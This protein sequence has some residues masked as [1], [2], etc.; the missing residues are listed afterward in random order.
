MGY[1]AVGAGHPPFAV[2]SRCRR[3]LSPHPSL[4]AR[5][6]GNYS[7]ATAAI[8]RF[9]ARAGQTAGCSKLVAMALQ[10]SR[11]RRWFAIGG[12]AVT[13]LV[14]GAYFYARHR[15]QNALKEVPG[16]MGINIQQSADGFTVSKS[17]A[18]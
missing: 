5:T 8:R 4:P 9:P 11:L 1:G 10:I 12:I 7:S 16:K 14:A 13:L 15:L 6:S 17:E 18:G 3:S 2:A